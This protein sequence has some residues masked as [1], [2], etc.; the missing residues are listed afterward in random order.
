MVDRA[1][2]QVHFRYVLADSWFSG[3][4]NLNWIVKNC[5]RDFIIAIKENS[6]AALNE[7]DKQVGRVQQYPGYGTGRVCSASLY[8]ATGISGVPN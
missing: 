5:K 7:A 4:E 2:G 8:G 6:K 3:A 1:T